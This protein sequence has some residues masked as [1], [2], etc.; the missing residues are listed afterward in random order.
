MTISA[1]SIADIW[2]GFVFTH[3]DKL[4]D[5]P[6]VAM[7]DQLQQQ[8]IRIAITME[9]MLGYLLCT[10]VAFIQPA[11]PGEAPTYPPMITN[12]WRKAIK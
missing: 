11:N 1:L 8:L 10:G 5:Q 3:V 2:A 7:I 9:A 6:T 4:E 12:A